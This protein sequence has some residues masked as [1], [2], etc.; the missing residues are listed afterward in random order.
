MS[1]QNGNGRAAVLERKTLAA[2]ALLS[3][4][5]I[6][7]LLQLWLITVALEAHL[8]AD[9][10]VAVPTFVASTVCFAVNLGLLKHLNTIDRQE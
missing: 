9:P 7:L 2:T 10:K 8:A 5:L 1:R 4:V 3:G 6:V